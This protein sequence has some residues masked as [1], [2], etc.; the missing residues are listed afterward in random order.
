MATRDGSAR[1]DRATQAYYQLRKLIVHGQL[2]PGTRI[3]ETEVA[4]KLEVSRTPVRSALQRLHQEG[5]I[6]AGREGE[7]NRPMVSP[8]TRE[9]AQE[10]FEIVGGIEAL[11]ALRAA[12]LPGP[13]RAQVV[14][15]LETANEALR[16][17]EAEPRPER[18]QFLALDNAFHAVYVEV[19]A[20]PRLRGLHDSVKPQ[21]ERYLR[22]YVSTL[23]GEIATSVAEHEHII[24]AIRAGAP[25]RAHNAALHNWRN[26]A[27]RL[28]RVIDTMGE[29]GS[30]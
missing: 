1:V 30:W 26:A 19:G 8:L 28:R 12:R 10:I 5:F 16:A 14:R 6:L 29:R 7:L 27:E 15:R 25:D 21:G 3:V 2:A 11:A 22:L 23:T 24:D 20:G 18:S 4:R 9:D 13:E 17:I